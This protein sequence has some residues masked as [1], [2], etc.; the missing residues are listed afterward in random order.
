[1]LTARTSTWDLVIGFEARANDYLSKPFEPEELLARVK[2][3]TELKA[4]ADRAISAE[5]GF[6]Q[7]QIKPHFHFNTL[8]TIASFCTTEPEY[9][10]K[11]IT[12]FAGYLRQSF[13]F[14]SLN[15]LFPLEKE[16]QLV[17][18]YVEIEKARFGDKLTIQLDVD[19]TIKANIFQLSIQPL[20]ENAIRHGV[21]KK[22]GC[23][24]I[25]VSVKRVNL[26]TVISVSDDGCG[27]DLDKLNTL[28]SHNEKNG[29]GLWNIDR[30]LKKLFG[31]GLTIESEPGAGT[32]VMF[33]IPTGGDKG[34]SRLLL[35]MMKGR[36]ATI[37]Q[38]CWKTAAGRWRWKASRSRSAL[39]NILGAT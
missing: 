20:V 10:R 22:S 27:I 29:I 34:C 35:L 1:M 14:K 16:L 23:G 2:T 19:K 39:W 18:S 25:T 30:R 37:W 17:K 28:L 11:L 15:T 5:N 21:R 36:P 7:A 13:D 4:S 38:S 8:S 32:N 33:S 12:E 26:E 24:V 31:K 3:L 9:A 6:L